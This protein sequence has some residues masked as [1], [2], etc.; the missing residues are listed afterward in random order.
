MGK[1]LP[2]VSEK[3]LIDDIDGALE[4]EEGISTRSELFS[5]ILLAPEQPFKYS[6]PLTLIFFD[7]QLCFSSSQ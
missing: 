3:I 7:H 5:L 1:K 2:N 4:K 6:R